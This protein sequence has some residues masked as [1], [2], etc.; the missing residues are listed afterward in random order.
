M[1][2]EIDGYKVES[3]GVQVSIASGS[4][5]R[6]VRLQEAELLRFLLRSRVVLTVGEATILVDFLDELSDRLGNDGC[7]DWSIRVDEE[8]VAFLRELAHEYGRDCGD[9]RA[10][11]VGE[12]FTGDNTTVVRL[13]RDKIAL[14][15]DG[16]EESAGGR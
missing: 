11:L 8:N 9:Y 3:D 1:T 5:P 2:T 10:P 13:L 7:N 4:D 16:D 15:F 12:K 14:Q 6:G